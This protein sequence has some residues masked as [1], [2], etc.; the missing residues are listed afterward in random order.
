MVVQLQ[1]VM[2]GEG[3]ME[4][5]EEGHLDLEGKRLVGL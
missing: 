2:T 4:R 1:T 3:V 5:E